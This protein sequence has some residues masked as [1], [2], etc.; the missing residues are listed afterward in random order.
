MLNALTRI[1]KNTGVSAVMALATV[2]ALYAEDVRVMAFPPHADSTFGVLT[3]VCFFL[4][5]VEFV[6]Y[7]ACVPG[8]LTKPSWDF[9][10]ETRSCK[11]DP[12]YLKCVFT[13]LTRVISSGSFYF[14]LDLIA[15]LS[16]VP[17][18]RHPLV[19][20]K[21]AAAAA[22][23]SS[24]VS[25]SHRTHLISHLTTRPCADTSAHLP[26]PLFPVGS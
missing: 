3:T 6:L 25:P 26:P 11:N 19:H 18:V 2:Y 10:H 23:G 14:Y 15:T 22:V 24:K 17:D 20:R 9:V 5:V 16:L 4:F 1:I 13:L 21:R 7:V 8:Y 12:L